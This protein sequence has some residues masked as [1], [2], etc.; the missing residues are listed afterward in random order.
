MTLTKA[1]VAGSEQGDV[2]MN[3]FD[4]INY[5]K[6]STGKQNQTLLHSYSHFAFYFGKNKKCKIMI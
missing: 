1:V 5:F 4:L 2:F 3:I 6:G